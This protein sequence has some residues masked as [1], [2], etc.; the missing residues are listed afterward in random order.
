MAKTIIG[1]EKKTGI[2]SR[3]IRFWLGKGLSRLSSA[4]KTA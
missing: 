1:V 2:L 4:T 3:A